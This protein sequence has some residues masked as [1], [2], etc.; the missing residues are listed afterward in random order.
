[1][2]VEFVF[3]DGTLTSLTKTLAAFPSIDNEKEMPVIRFGTTINNVSL[4]NI[5]NLLRV[6]HGK[7]RIDLQG[8]DL[9]RT[10]KRSRHYR[11]VEDDDIGNLEEEDRQ[12]IFYLYQ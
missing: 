12:Y 9:I 4:D 11:L 10:F 7:V 2:E 8:T 3:A 5:E 6:C 1:M